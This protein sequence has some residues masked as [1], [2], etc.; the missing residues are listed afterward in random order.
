MRESFK[1][2]ILYLLIASGI[3]LSAI[4]LFYCFKFQLNSWMV[5]LWLIM[6][7]YFVIYLASQVYFVWYLGPHQA[8]KLA[9]Q[10]R[11][12]HGIQFSNLS[13]SDQRQPSS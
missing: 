12:T 6:L 1:K 5:L 2:P 7:I 4:V 10:R 11:R 13:L 8:I 9:V 3:G